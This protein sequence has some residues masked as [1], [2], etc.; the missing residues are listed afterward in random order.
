[1]GGRFSSFGRGKAEGKGEG[2]AEEAPDT[3]GRP[4]L[5]E[6]GGKTTGNKLAD[7]AK[8]LAVAGVVGA[9]IALVVTVF[10]KI[11]EL[12]SLPCKVLPEEMKDMCEAISSCSC[13]CLC[14]II[15]VGG[16]FMFMTS[17]KK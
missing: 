7:A 3:A 9:I 5:A 6:G 2:K 12:F 13:C 11:K 17:S 14:M 4:E 10:N 1:M 15:I 8:P 16:G